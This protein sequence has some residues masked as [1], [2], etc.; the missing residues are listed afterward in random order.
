MLID[1]KDFL[2]F[3]DLEKKRKE[4]RKKKVKPI[5]GNALVTKRR[6]RREKKL[7]L[8]MKCSNELKTSAKQKEDYLHHE[9]DVA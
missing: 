1:E 9:V 6:R 7:L 3:V 8:S 2:S 5:L 4:R